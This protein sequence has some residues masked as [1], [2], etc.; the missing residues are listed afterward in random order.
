MSDLWFH[1]SSDTGMISIVVASNS[2]W[3]ITGMYSNTSLLARRIALY[4]HDKEGIR[5]ERQ[6]ALA[7][8]QDQTILHIVHPYI[9][10]PH[11]SISRF[12]GKTGPVDPDSPLLRIS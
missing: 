11:I 3:T 12:P 6:I 7:I 9:S 2:L 8:Y 10:I 1:G 5:D 4:R